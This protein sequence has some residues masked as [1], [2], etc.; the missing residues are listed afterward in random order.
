MRTGLLSSR[1]RRRS[2]LD[3]T[4]ITVTALLPAQG[5]EEEG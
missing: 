2:V 5:E 4:N 3:M 1:S